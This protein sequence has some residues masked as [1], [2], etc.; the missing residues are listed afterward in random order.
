MSDA[1]ALRDLVE[2]TLS[3]HDQKIATALIYT[4]FRGN[5]S[6]LS[7]VISLHGHVSL[8]I[9]GTTSKKEPL[10][11][12]SRWNGRYVA[13]EEASQKV[14]EADSLADLFEAVR[15]LYPP[16]API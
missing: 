1:V 14:L 16:S 6:R 3:E 5:F 4:R 7:K 15:A 9:W 12:I 10:F 8:V 2:E 13:I 11:K